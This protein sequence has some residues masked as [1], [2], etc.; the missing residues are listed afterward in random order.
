LA[1]IDACG[2][3]TYS[4]GPTW[5]GYAGNDSFTYAISNGYSVSAPATVHVSVIAPTAHGDWFVDGPQGYAREGYSFSV[6][7]PGVLANDTYTTGRPLVAY[8][9]Y[10]LQT[11]GTTWRGGTV[12]L[13][14]DGGFLYTPPPGFGGGFDM[15]WYAAFDADLAPYAYSPTVPVSIWVA[16]DHAPVAADYNYRVAQDTPLSV[17]A[18]GVLAN[19]TDADGDSLTVASVA[20]LSA[21]TLGQPVA[22]AHGTVTLNANGSF[23]YTPLAG[24]CGPDTF[25]YQA[26][27]GVRNSNQATVTITVNTPPV[28]VGDEFDVMEGNTL[29]IG[30]PGVLA[31]DTD[32][33][34]D[35]LTVVSIIGLANGSLG[36]P[37]ATA[38]G[39]VTL[40]T[41]GSFSYIPE[42]GY[43]GTDEFSY[44]ASDGPAVSDFATATIFVLPPTP[45]ILSLTADPD[46]VT[47]K[48]T[49]LSVVAEV[50]GGSSNL[51]Y[52]WSVESLPDGA[53]LPQLSDNASA[54]A[55]DITATFTKAG[56]YTFLVTV[57]NS[58]STA[59]DEVTVT[60]EQTATSIRVSPPMA[61]V[62]KDDTKQLTAIFDDQFGD[63]MTTP[64]SV[65]WA[66]AS[67]PG[68]VSENGL[69]TAPS[70]D[71]GEAV[72]AAQGGGALASVTIEVTNQTT[73]IDFDDL[74]GGT[75][76]TNQY[77]AA[78]FSCDTGFYNQ[79]VSDWGP[80]VLGTLPL[81][82][83]GRNYDR[84]LY[85]DFTSPVDSLM[86]DYGYINT[87]SG[88]T[89]GE[90]NVFEDG[91]LY[92]TTSIPGGGS[93][94]T[95]DLSSYRHV[96]RIEIVNVTDPAGLVYDNFRFSADSVQLT[97]HRT[98]DLQG[99]EVSDDDKKSDDPSKYVILVDNDY[100]MAD[101]TS[102][103][104]ADHAELPDAGAGTG[105]SDL[106]KISLKKLSAGMTQGAVQLVLSDP[107]AVRLFTSDGSLLYA[108]GTTNDDVLTLDLADPSGY[109]AG[110]QSDDVDMWVEGLHADPDFDLAI[111]TKNTAGKV[112]SS[113]DIHMA[114]AD[115]T[116]RNYDG[117]PLHGV[118]P[119]WSD[120]LLSEVDLING[121]GT[122]FQINDLPQDY[123]FKN[124]IRGLP[125]GVESQLRVTSDDDPSDTYTDDLDLIAD[126]LVSHRFAALYGSEDILYADPDSDL[127]IAQRQAIQDVLGVNIVHN[128]GEESKLLTG[129]VANPTDSHTRRLVIRY[130]VRIVFDNP[131]GIYHVGDH[132]TGR[133]SAPDNSPNCFFTVSDGLGHMQR[134]A[135]VTSFPFDFVATKSGFISILATGIE[136]V[137]GR[138]PANN[139]YVWVLD[140]GQDISP[141]QAAAWDALKA[142]GV[143]V[144][145]GPINRNR[146]IT[147]LYAEM[148]NS[149]PQKF[150]WAGMAAF[151]SKSVGD[152]M[153]MA[154]DLYVLAQGGTLIGGPNPGKLLKY[155]GE[156]NMAIFMDMYPQMLAYQTG[157]LANIQAMRDA[158]QINPEQLLAWTNID[159]GIASNNSDQIW[160]GNTQIAHVEQTIT[161]QDVLDRAPSLWA[162]ATNFVFSPW[163]KSPIPGDSS[164]FQTFAPDTNFGN[165][166]AR[167]E[168]F[169]EKMVPAWKNWRRTNQQIDLPT[170]LRGGY[171]Q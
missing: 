71:T 35:P 146:Q 118:K 70:D 94:Q 115:W 110:L 131:T 153:A 17:N 99:Q 63:A 90:V 140:A 96:T 50:D 123:F 166:D 62:H 151:A 162:S 168:W 103:L 76:V 147:K 158:G 159:A 21:G 119:I 68:T 33:N 82:T 10:S 127:T 48:S 161:L 157:G 31:N 66:L 139:A 2:T 20:G 49:E 109:L 78:T 27:D 104:E 32:D 4:W 128:P 72:L 122:P 73:V 88:G 93:I 37:V 7:P 148:F 106:A 125:I 89:V 44:Q 59:S 74:A 165:G 26:S 45:A 25:T 84:N 149:D 92:A 117:E 135:N 101:G 80:K 53:F 11:S 79:V 13:N 156:G 24:Y 120:A 150:D 95:M 171:T 144:P 61:F 64:P 55:S 167:F 75:T 145:G 154:T 138:I 42:P 12:T 9:N 43:F 160:Q 107:S 60:V 52:T 124:L 29:P 105:D 152:G 57:D 1:T 77:S 87:A 28:A 56:E 97:A 98:G 155:L 30:A 6:G 81:D 40:N 132:I 102:S 19:D 65:S 46:D 133:V 51:V 164:T 23:N 18:D 111:L 54:T 113:D 67:G 39:S 69:Y 3:I 36:Q 169:K 41:N 136:G 143:N 16:A 91:Q 58:G 85:V 137:F 129:P 47:G 14:N 134:S 100:L 116:V 38:H 130:A 170:L 15:F 163:I 108:S 83:D 5:A 114:I 112:T 142:D 8:L 141:W 86:F 22:T 126:Q 34:N 121:L